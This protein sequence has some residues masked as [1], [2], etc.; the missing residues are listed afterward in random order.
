MK[1]N[2]FRRNIEEGKT[3]E[4]ALKDK[5]HNILF[6]QSVRLIEWDNQ[7][8]YAMNL[9]RHGVDGISEIKEITWDVK[10]RDFSYYKYKDILLE[11]VS[12]EETGKPG[13]FYYSIADF[14]IYT[15]KDKFNQYLIDGHFIFIQNP[16]LKKW[17]EENKDNYEDKKAKTIDKQTNNEW[18][19]LNKA[20][21]IRDFPM[22][23]ILQFNPLVSLNKQQLDLT[24]YLL[25]DDYKKRAKQATLFIPFV[26]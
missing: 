11:T 24:K 5:L 7:N 2:E 20:I 6:S 25:Y 1:I 3:A 10:V 12:V 21:P 26:R 23:T 15:W 17:F 13:W 4:K 22:G 19:T 14:I 18:H 8:V 16:V 9:Q